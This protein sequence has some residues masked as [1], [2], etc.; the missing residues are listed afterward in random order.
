MK[1]DFV[2]QNLK[3]DPAGSLWID[4]HRKIGLYLTWLIINLFPNVTANIITLIM[5]PLNLVSVGFIYFGITQGSYLYLIISFLIF[6]FSISL[7]CV[8][9][10]IAR[11]KKD[12]SSL[13]I[14]YDRLVHNISHPLVFIFIGAGIT[15]VTD[16]I[17]YMILFSILGILSEFPPIETSVKDVKCSFTNQVLYKETKNFELTKYVDININN[18]E[19]KKENSNNN[20][21]S[22]KQFLL[23]LVKSIFSIKTLYLTLIVDMYISQQETFYLTLVFAII[24]TIAILVNDISA[25]KDL[26]RFL[27]SLARLEYRTRD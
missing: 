14:L 25:R 17:F 8:D 9:G 23:K 20:K 2:K 18:I 21:N 27:N 3:R 5:L 1:F 10:N 24:Y 13:G 12:T 11:L 6:F 16:N 26:G 22:L 15:N 4:L 19:D 7:D